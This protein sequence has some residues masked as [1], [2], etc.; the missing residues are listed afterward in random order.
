MAHDVFAVADRLVSHI[1]SICPDEVDLVAY[2]GSHA[3]G[4]ATERSD[5]DFF[6]VPRPGCE[7]QPGQATS[8]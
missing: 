3:Q 7:P 1:K 4:V 6:Y 2:Y 5:L 8:F